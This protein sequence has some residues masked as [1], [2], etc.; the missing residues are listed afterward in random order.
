M[1]DFTSPIDGSTAFSRLDL[2]KG[3][4]QIPMASKNFPKAA[5]H[6]PLWDVRIPLHAL[7][8][9]EHRQYL[10]MDDGPNP[11]PGPPDPGFPPVKKVR[12]TLVPATQ[13]RRNPHRTVQGFPLSSDLTFGGS[14]LWLLQRQPSSSSG[15]QT[16]R[17]LSGNALSCTDLS[18]LR[19]KPFAFPV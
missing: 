17:D 15:L 14:I 12:F 2:Q 13:L 11:N 9:P 7:W 6:H 10:S 5:N 3:Y 4:Y 19:L 8:T 18:G 16:E 1:A